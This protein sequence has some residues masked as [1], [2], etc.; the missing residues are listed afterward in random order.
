MADSAERESR[1]LVGW[2]QVGLLVVALAVG[3]YFARA[4]SV[5][6]IGEDSVRSGEAPS[7]RV[8]LPEAG[9]HALTV[10]LTGEVHARAPVALHP[11]RRAA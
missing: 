11:R 4:P 6:P 2:A 1:G 9:S 10:A 3:I 5:A 7:V 8:L